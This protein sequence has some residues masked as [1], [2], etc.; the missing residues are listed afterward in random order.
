MVPILFATGFE[1]IEALAPADI[2]R[3]AGVEV[4]LVGVTGEKVTGSHGIEVTMD[5]VIDALNYS[6]VDAVILP[7]GLPGTTNLEASEAVQKLIDHC[8]AEGKLVA[9]ICAAPSILA[10]KGLLASREATAFPNF[11]KDLVD[12]GAHLSREYVVQDGN[13][14]TARGMGVATQFGLKLAELLADRE[15]SE[16]IR[17]SIQWEG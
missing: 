12:G 13:F 11:Q 10:H 15:T 6:D 3:R 8:V 9:A 5:T 14:L 16:K 4:R 7:G 2:L 1:E 17:A